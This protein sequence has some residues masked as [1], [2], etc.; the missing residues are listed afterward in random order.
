MNKNNYEDE[1]TR[2]EQDEARTNNEGTQYD[3]E[4]SESAKTEESVTDEPKDQP[5]DK[6]LKDKQAPAGKQGIKKN[7]W[8]KVAAGGGAGLLLGSAAT[9]FA[10]F[11]PHPDDQ[12]S[13]EPT[14]DWVDGKVPVSHD[15]ND[16]MSFQEA[17]DTARA[18]VGPGGV[19]EWHDYIYN[20][21]TEDEWDAMSQAER[22]EFGSHFDWKGDTS[23]DDA[24]AEVVA[25]E[26]GDAHLQ[27][28]QS[29][30][31]TAQTDSNTATRDVTDDTTTETHTTDAHSTAAETTP[32]DPDVEIL[33]VVHDE[34]S[35][36]NIAGVKV[37]GE[38][39][40]L[41]DVD[42]DNVFDVIAQDTN[43]DGQL[44]GDE[45]VDISDQNLT[46]DDL[47]GVQN[48]AANDMMASSDVESDY[49]TDD[50][51][52]LDA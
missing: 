8:G 15:V 51:T 21:R 13:D 42:N 39:A 16:D 4:T 12:G 30:A 49:I 11:A 24:V 41:I 46:T 10:S 45:M 9:V 48:P 31:S 37:N 3:S 34:E 27:E 7:R 28:P 52:G 14:P 29:A 35:D 44:Q 26:D 38:D 18:E 5:G 6:Q 23:E 43:H 47:G 1:H 17:F 32:A 22:D 2:Y 25:H 20:T 40:I 19:F 33:G 50:A 36:M